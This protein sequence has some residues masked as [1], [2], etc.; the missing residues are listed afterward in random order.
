MLNQLIRRDAV[1][2]LTKAVS[3]EGRFEGYASF[4]N[5]PDDDF[6]GDTIAPG[7]FASGLKKLKAAGRKLKMLYQHDSSR[8]IGVYED[9]H[10][11]GQ[12]LY[13]VGQLTLGVPDADNTYKL[14]K[15]GALDAMSIG[16]YTR[17]ESYDKK[18]DKLT[19]L[20]IELQEVS[21]V[22][23]PALDTA[24]IVTVKS[25]TDAERYLRDVGNMSIKEAKKFIATVKGLPAPRDA[26]DALSEVRNAIKSLNI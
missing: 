3:D 10:E 25:I 19:L 21:V 6:Y 8:P 16:G 17:A 23:F 13:V 15:S 26:G 22:T 4:F 14:L 11:D 5:K 7:A 2:T 24:R 18:T 12:G 9:A 20:E 1:L